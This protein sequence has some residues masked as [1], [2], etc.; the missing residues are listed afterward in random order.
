VQLYGKQ[1]NNS[2]FYRFLAAAGE[3]PSKKHLRIQWF[4]RPSQGN[5][6]RDGTGN[7]FDHN[8]DLIRNQQGINSPQQGI[9]DL[10]YRNRKMARKRWLAAMKPSGDAQ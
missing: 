3:N 8:R 5:S 6:L 1:G 9:G 4:A 10:R 2:E 7:Q